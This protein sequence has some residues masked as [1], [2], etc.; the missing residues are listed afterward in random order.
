VGN[1]NLVRSP[2]IDVREN[3]NRANL[4]TN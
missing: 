2:K 4:A 3:V 1:E